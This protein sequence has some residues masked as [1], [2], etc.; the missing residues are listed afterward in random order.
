M[1]L[2]GLKR[3][4]GGLEKR[5][6]DGCEGCRYTAI[7][8]HIDSWP[9]CQVCGRPLQAERVVVIEERIVTRGDDGE[10]REVDSGTLA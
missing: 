6:D 8:E 4:L 3:R 7:I 2:D 10:I 9:A 5:V 1:S